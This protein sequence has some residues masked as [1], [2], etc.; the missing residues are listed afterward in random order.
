MSEAEKAYLW[1]FDLHAKD[2]REEFRG[3][4]CERLSYF[5]FL[6]FKAAVVRTAVL[7]LYKFKPSVFLNFLYLLCSLRRHCWHS[8]L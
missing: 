3:A 8:T 6:F 1:S 2:E 5:G 7:I 4:E